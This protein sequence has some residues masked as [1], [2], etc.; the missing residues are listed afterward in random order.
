MRVKLICTCCSACFRNNSICN[1]CCLVL[2]SC[3]LFS[4]SSS[5][6]M[7]CSLSDFFLKNSTASPHFFQICSRYLQQIHLILFRGPCIPW[8]SFWILHLALVIRLFLPLVEKLSSLSHSSPV[9]GSTS[10][11]SQSTPLASSS[12]H[13]MHLNLAWSR[14]QQSLTPLLSFIVNFGWL[15]LFNLSGISSQILSLS[16]LPFLN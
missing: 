4:S 9:S 13:C 14:F 15:S 3:F 11:N 16:G 10:S 2:T 1:S 6:Q 8:L 12:S 5:W 7:E